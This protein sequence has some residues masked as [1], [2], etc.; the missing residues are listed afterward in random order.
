[1]FGTCGEKKKQQVGKKIL[2]KINFGFRRKRK[3]VKENFQNS[4]LK[5][6]IKQEKRETPFYF[7]PG[8]QTEHKFI[9]IPFLA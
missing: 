7:F 2:G 6:E 9:D 3:I 4:L 8:F 1:M 5:L